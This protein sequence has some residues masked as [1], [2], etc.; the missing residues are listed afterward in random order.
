MPTTS[1]RLKDWSRGTPSCQAL[2]T[3]TG[4]AQPERV[5]VAASKSS[6]TGAA[7]RAVHSNPSVARMTR[8]AKALI[9]THYS[10]GVTPFTGSVG[11]P[12]VLGATGARQRSAAAWVWRL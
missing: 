4:W 7:R 8:S 10:P 6:A 2:S 1:T 5:A 9:R 3:L 12:S 11:K